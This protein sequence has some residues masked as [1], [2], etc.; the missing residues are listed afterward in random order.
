MPRKILREKPP[1]DLVNRFLNACSLEKGIE[2]AKS[3]AK[4]SIS[5]AAIENL[6][7]ELEPYYLPCLVAEYIHTIPFTP[8][9]AITILRHI[10]QAHSIQLYS[11]E[12]T[13]AGVRG[14]WYKLQTT[15]TIL[16]GDIQVDFT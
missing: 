1:L 15:K 12:R 10:L 6:L 5:V 8:S 3:F 14:V 9:S 4:T 13:V 11:M 2:D 16:Q 7:P